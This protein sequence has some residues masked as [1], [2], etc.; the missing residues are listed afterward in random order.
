MIVIETIRLHAMAKINLGLDVIGKRPDG[1]HDLRMIMQMINLHD[2][3]DIERI[4]EPVIKLSTNLPFL[5]CD[6]RNIAYRAARKLLDEYAPEGGVDI[7]IEKHI[8]VAAG[9]AG[10]ST[11]CAAVLYG[12]NK[13]FSLGLG[14]EELMD[15]GLSLGAD[16]P[17]CLMKR[18]ALAEGIG[19][20]LTEISPLPD[21]FIVVAKP[22]VSISTKH[23]YSSLK[24]DETILH[25]DIDGICEALSRS[26]LHAVAEKLGNVLESVSI[27]E[28]PVIR[29]IKELIKGCGSLGTLMSGSGPSVFGLFDDKDK[30]RAAYDS[31]TESELAQQVFLTRPATFD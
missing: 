27:R 9:M 28:H 8:P 4:E 21:C 16:V 5:P 23:V 18:T 25:P 31:L 3:I 15:I 10:G 14:M 2:R 22:P 24:L 20:K 6:D 1:Y 17:F 13:L 12:I 30:A 19:E 7:R 29:E 26:D 11:N